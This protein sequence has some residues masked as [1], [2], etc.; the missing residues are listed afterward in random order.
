[1][2]L[3]LA[4]TAD[5]ETVAAVRGAVARAGLV[6][7]PV[8]LPDRNAW[9]SAG[10]AEAVSRSETARNAAAAPSRY[11]AARSPRSTR[12]ATRA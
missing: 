9:W 5:P 12:G 1:M 11:E 7:A 8:P 4:P 10:L 3:D 2:E 6:L